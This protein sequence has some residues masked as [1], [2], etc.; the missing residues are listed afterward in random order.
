MD[1]GRETIDLP[2]FQLEEVKIEGAVFLS[3]QGNQIASFIRA[4]FFVGENQVCRFAT[5]RGAIIDN[6]QI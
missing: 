6:F 5:E 2:Q 1:F 4:D 3:F